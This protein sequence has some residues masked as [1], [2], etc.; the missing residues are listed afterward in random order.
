M[1]ARWLSYKGVGELT[2]LS[3]STIRRLVDEGK[4]SAP[5]EITAGRKV[6]E[7]ERVVA[8]ME[9]MLAARRRARNSENAA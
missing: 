9:E 3:Q 1:T 8:E 5:E 2:S 7:R 4:L 6:F